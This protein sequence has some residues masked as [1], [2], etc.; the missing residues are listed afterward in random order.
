MGN[1]RPRPKLLPEKLLAIREFLNVGQRDMAQKL[2]FE[3]ISH[4]GLQYELH[5]GRISEYEG[6]KRE[7]NLFLL[8]AYGRLGKVHL[9]SLADD[10]MPVDNFRTRLG[11]E[12]CDV[13]FSEPIEEQKHN[14]PVTL[15]NGTR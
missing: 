2:Q 9:E 14:Q 7:P 6:G 13:P 11:R 5:R 12:I 1:P 3:I 4:T 10:E 8:I 15:I